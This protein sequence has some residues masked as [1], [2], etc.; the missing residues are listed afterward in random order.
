MPDTMM[1]DHES[2]VNSQ[3]VSAVPLSRLKIAG[4]K[5]VLGLSGLNIINGFKKSPLKAGSSS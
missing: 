4:M 3:Q 1:R 5:M 2:F